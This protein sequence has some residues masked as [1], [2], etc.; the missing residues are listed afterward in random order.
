MGSLSSCTFEW[1]EEDYQKLME[2][3]TGEPVGSGVSTIHKAISREKL[4]RH[5]RG[6][7]ETA[8]LFEV[9]MLAVTGATGCS[10]CSAV[11]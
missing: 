4:A 10:R 11:Q 9:L 5:C 3:K 8:E 1:D 6:A 7:T 2:G